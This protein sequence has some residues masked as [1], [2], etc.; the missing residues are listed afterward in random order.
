MSA[1]NKVIGLAIIVLV[2]FLIF[3]ISER[4]IRKKIEEVDKEFP[5]LEYSDTIYGEVSSIYNPP[6]T[7][8]SPHFVRVIFKNGEKWTIYVNGQS[9]NSSEI[10]LRKV[11]SSNAFMEKKI[12]SDTIRIKSEEA[13]FEFLLKQND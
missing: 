11:L 2:G 4:N 9:S 5:R 7:R 12:N 3:Q 8:S 10:S 13:T 6:K 1:R